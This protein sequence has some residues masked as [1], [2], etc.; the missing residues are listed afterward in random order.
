MSDY[1]RY[2]EM[3]LKHNWYPLGYCNGDY[4]FTWTKRL[5]SKSQAQ[6]NAIVEHNKVRF[7]VVY[8]KRVNAEQA[9]ELCNL[10][11]EFTKL[12]QARNDFE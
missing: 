7:K 2:S 4:S 11:S 8:Q 1:E 12:W 6:L 10:A 3:L 5:S 9:T